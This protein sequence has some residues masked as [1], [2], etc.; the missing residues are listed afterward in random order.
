MGNV[1]TAA[2]AIAS[3]AFPSLTTMA[4]NDEKVC[5]TYV[6]LQAMEQLIA[7]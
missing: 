3:V 6:Q 2:N 4:V 1:T 7:I 5:S